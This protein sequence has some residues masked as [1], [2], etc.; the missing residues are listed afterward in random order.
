M[1]TLLKALANL[2]GLRDRDELDFALI[3]LIRNFTPWH[4]QS[5]RLLRAVGPLED[6]RWFTCARLGPHQ[7]KPERDLNWSDWRTL[8]KLED[9]PNRQTAITLETIECTGSGPCTTIFPINTQQAVCSLLEVESDHPLGAEAQAQI[10]SVLWIYQN[11]QGLLDYGAFLRAAVEQDSLADGNGPDRRLVH[12]GQSYWLAVIGIDHFKRINFRF[13]DQIYRFGGEEFVV[14]MR[15]TDHADALCALERFRHKVQEHSFPQVGT[16][17]VS[18]GFSALR[19]DDT[20][21]NAFDRADKAVYYAKAHGR[22]QV[23]SYSELVR[24]GELTE[25]LDTTLDADF[26]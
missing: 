24:I 14:L 17:T 15:C 2:S 1:K 22:N 6:Q 18:M 7:I 9:F 5:S 21:G 3:T 26:F 19:A 13:H 12:T 20:P 4:I 23:C 25:P 8:P 11:L 10:D 16:I